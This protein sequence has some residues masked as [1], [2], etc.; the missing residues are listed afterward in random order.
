MTRDSLQINSK[1]SDELA[2]ECLE[3]IKEITGEPINVS[4]DMDNFY[5]VLKS[6]VLLCKLVNALE[7]GKIKKITESAMGKFAQYTL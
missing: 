2:Q 4:G 7:P 5:E 3:W 6:G 1:Y